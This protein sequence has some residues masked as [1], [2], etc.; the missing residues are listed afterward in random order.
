MPRRKRDTRLPAPFLRSLW[1]DD[2]AD[3]PAGYPF[4]LPWLT[5]DFA[6]EFEQPVTI[7]MGENGT[8]KST[9]I[10]AIALLAGFAT[11]GGGAWRGGAL[12]PDA[13]GAEALA[14]RLRTG[15]L[16][17]MARGWFLRAGSF[18]GV[19]ATVRGNYLGRS[20]GE[21]FAQLVAERMQGQ[22]VFLLDEPEAALS[23]RR[24]AEL[25][26]FLADI[27]T[28]AEAQVIL[29]THSPI[30][31]AVPGAALWRLTHREIAPV[32]L[33]ETD[34]FRLWQAFAGDPDAFVRA[35]QDGDLGDL[36]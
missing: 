14:A 26:A 35:A 20:H 28:T 11:S 23:P 16:P 22:G 8:G 33:R 3:R 31:M 12:D 10:E 25:L 6:L 29:A 13:E 1:L 27:Q 19:A 30:L 5:D 21:G 34:H 24:Q 7:L 17:R 36:V 4:T 9:L 15:W 2:A 32:A 18:E